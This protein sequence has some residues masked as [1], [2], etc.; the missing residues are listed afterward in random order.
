MKGTGMMKVMKAREAFAVAFVLG[1]LSA[2]LRI[3]LMK[4]NCDSLIRV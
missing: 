3:R 4:R 1:V 2:S